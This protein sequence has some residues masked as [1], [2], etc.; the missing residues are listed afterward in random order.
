MK[1]LDLPLL[2]N[3]SQTFRGMT[4]VEVYNKAIGMFLQNTSQVHCL[5]TR[6][7]AVFE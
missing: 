6:N 5:K 4:P 1:K 2:F 3:F 7:P